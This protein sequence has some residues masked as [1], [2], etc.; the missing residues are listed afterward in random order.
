M[1]SFL[2]FL[3]DISFL[4]DG[5]RTCSIIYLPF[6]C[7]NLV[8]FQLF[9]P[10]FSTKM[11]KNFLNQQGGSSGRLQLALNFEI[12]KIKRNAVVIKYL[13]D[14]F[15]A[16]AY[17]STNFSVKYNIF[18]LPFTFNSCLVSLSFA[19][20]MKHSSCSLSLVLAY[21]I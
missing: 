17:K 19:K 6:V 3:L 2:I 5:I 16:F 15:F 1:T 8:F 14:P 10:L 12:L 21:T 20:D 18:R 7:L 11:K 9:L 4:W 13:S